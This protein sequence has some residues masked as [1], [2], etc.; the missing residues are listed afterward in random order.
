MRGTIQEVEHEKERVN[1]HARQPKT[2]PNST[3]AAQVKDPKATESMRGTIQEVEHEQE[4]TNRQGNPNRSPTQQQ[5]LRSKTQKQREHAGD[6]PGRQ[7][8][9]Q[10]TRTKER[11]R[12]TYIYTYIYYITGGVYIYTYGSVRS[13]VA[14]NLGTKIHTYMAMDAHWHG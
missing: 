11:Q 8:R 4:R 13:T 3:T 10:R 9:R 1:E 7:S 2:K 14:P 5:H 6:N 12:Y